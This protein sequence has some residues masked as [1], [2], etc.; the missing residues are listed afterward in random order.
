MKHLKRFNEN[1][2]STQNAQL[3]IITHNSDQVRK[4]NEILLNIG[5]HLHVPPTIDE[6]FARNEKLY[7]YVFN[8]NA[9]GYPEKYAWLQIQ[10]RHHDVQHIDFKDC[11]ELT[12]LGII[13]GNKLGLI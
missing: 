1:R 5:Y 10:K 13:E 2:S 6:Y 7:I 11:D 8:V 9:A 3:C 4:V 12:I